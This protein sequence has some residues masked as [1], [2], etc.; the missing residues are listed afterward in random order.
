MSRRR[1]PTARCLGR[2][3]LLALVLAI[4]APPLAIGAPAEWAPD[5]SSLSG[6]AADGDEPAAASAVVWEK[7]PRLRD[8]YRRERPS[9]SGAPGVAAVGARAPPATF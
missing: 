2:L 1:A 7:A 5:E 4:L 8:L 9:P 6:D 3:L